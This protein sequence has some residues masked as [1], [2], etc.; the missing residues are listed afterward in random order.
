MLFQEQERLDQVRLP[1]VDHPQEYS[2]YPNEYFA[3]NPDRT[4]Y[5]SVK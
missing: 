2:V 4:P 3:S 5:P 1:A